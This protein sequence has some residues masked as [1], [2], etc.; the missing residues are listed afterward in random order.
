MFAPSGEFERRAKDNRIY[1]ARVEEV[2]EKGGAIQNPGVR[3]V[4]DGHRN[5]DY[6]SEVSWRTDLEPQT[7]AYSLRVKVTEEGSSVLAGYETSYC[8]VGGNR[9]AMAPPP[10]PSSMIFSGYISSAH[11]YRRVPDSLNAWYVLYSVVGNPGACY[12]VATMYYGVRHDKTGCIPTTVGSMTVGILSDDIP[13]RVESVTA[14]LYA[15]STLIPPILGRTFTMR[16]N[17]NGTGY[18]FK[19]AIDLPPSAPPSP[20]SA[21]SSPPKESTCK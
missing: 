11:A 14:D 6:K 18:V 21:F 12:T 19:D 17:E 20:P 4:I 10:V 9:A 3:W 2:D 7:S 16:L 15:D 13:T 1:V 8:V 5:V